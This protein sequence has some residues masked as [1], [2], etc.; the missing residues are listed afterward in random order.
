MLI[1]ICMIPN[2]ENEIWVDIIGF[3]GLY[4]VSSMG[5]VKALAR[6][7]NYGRW[8]KERL[9]RMKIK[10]K[11]I[12]DTLFKNGV[13]HV[14]SRHRTVAIHFISNPENKPEVN[15]KFGKKQD[16][17]ASELEWNTKSE[18]E[19]HAHRMK[20]KQGVRGE[21]NNFTKMKAED[22][23]A[24]YNSPLSTWKLGDIYGLNRRYVWAIK[25]GKT[26][27]HL[28]KPSPDTPSKDC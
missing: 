5:R 2:L 14:L 24:I 27:K 21:K 17:R 13:R 6:M 3:E 11:Y 15:H 25:A 10:G 7:Y 9:F 4:Q 19:L 16:N 26:W 1:F 23:L 22:I 18:N 8:K 20:L 28:T 12:Q